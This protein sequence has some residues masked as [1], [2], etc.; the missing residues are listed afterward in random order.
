MFVV[1]SRKHHL[2]FE[3]FDKS[4]TISIGKDVGYVVTDQ[5]VATFTNKQVTQPTQS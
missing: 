2:S 4:L 3:H 5:H 1:K